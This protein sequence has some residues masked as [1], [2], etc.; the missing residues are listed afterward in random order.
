MWSGACQFDNR[1]AFDFK[2][3]DFDDEKTKC[4]SMS[5]QKYPSTDG[6]IGAGVV[7]HNNYD[8]KNTLVIDA[9]V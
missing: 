8:L 7:L 9:P 6:N 1:V 4:L 5:I 3:A 2:V